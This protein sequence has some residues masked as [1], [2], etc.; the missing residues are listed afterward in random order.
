MEEIKLKVMEPTASNNVPSVTPEAPA[1]TVSESAAQV[2]PTANTNY[3]SFFQRL[4]AVFVDGFVYGL[5]YM[6]VA[7]PLFLVAGTMGAAQSGAL[8]MP[9]AGN[10]GTYGT[11]TSVQAGNAVAGLMVMGVV[12]VV[13]L[14]LVILNAI[15]VG[16]F[17]QS[18]GKKLL[19]IKVVRLDNGEVPGI[20]KGFMRELLG[21]FVS[22]IIPLALGYL[23]MLWDGQK[24][25]I[26]DKIAGTVVVKV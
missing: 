7:V 11:T 6:V 13:I 24:Q 22:G 23:W 4:L 26:H 1:M 3:A 8:T 16:K 9:Q 10:V 5:V 2:A 25:A 21:K 19:K 15:L 12:W 20:G 14:L 18:L 17:G